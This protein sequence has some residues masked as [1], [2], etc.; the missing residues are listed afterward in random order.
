MVHLPHSKLPFPLYVVK[1]SD[2]RHSESM[3]PWSALMMTVVLLFMGLAS[4]V[5]AGF[6]ADH[7]LHGAMQTHKCIGSLDSKTEKSTSDSG[8]CEAVCHA[9][10]ILGLPVMV[11]MEQM[12][13]N[14]SPLNVAE[15]TLASLRAATPDQPPRLA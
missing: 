11:A 8:Y 3:K 10:Q 7:A 1:Q 13:S 6:D 9:A 15:G 12:S 14:D 2:L 4:A 5:H